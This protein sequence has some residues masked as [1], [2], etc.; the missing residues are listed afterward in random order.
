[1]G[2]ISDVILTI[3]PACNLV[4]FYQVL[5]SPFNSNGSD[6][7][8]TS[9]SVLRTDVATIDR[10]TE[11]S[12]KDVQQSTSSTRYCIFT[13]HRPVTKIRRSISV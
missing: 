8:R 13:A 11:F 10:G 6:R 3:L 9:A 5:I 7:P 4:Y 1:M 2:I 12:L